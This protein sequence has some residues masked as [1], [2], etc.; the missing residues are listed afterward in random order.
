MRPASPFVAFI[1]IGFF[2]V[3]MLWMWQPQYSS[4]ETS[5][6][7]DETARGVF[8][9]LSKS[10]TMVVASSEHGRI[11]YSTDKGKSW[12]KSQTGTEQSLTDIFLLNEGLGW[13]VGFEGA[14]LKTMD[15]GLTWKTIKSVDI[16]EPPLFAI[17]FRDASLG[18]AV[19]A[20]SMVY[21][22]LDGG[23]TWHSLKLEYQTHLYAITQTDDSIIWIAGENHALFKSYDSGVT[24]SQ[25][26]PPF[27]ESFFGFLP[28]ENHQLLTYGIR[29]R[30]AIFNDAGFV[31]SAQEADETLSAGMQMADGR[32]VLAGQRGR[33]LI[34]TS[35]GHPFKHVTISKL[36]DISA[37]TEVEDA[38]IVAGALGILRIPKEDLGL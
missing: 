3:A 36:E 28:L 26:E 33:L 19:G 20:D 22:T 29:G 38:V 4:L 14:I 15:G 17:W 34:G 32:I 18:L 25:V 37:L 27:L 13:A 16:N 12:K 8:Y 2:I 24:W 30:V 10:S 11:F 31:N 6:A 35:K 5:P 21:R 1:G 7:V 23:D 9:A